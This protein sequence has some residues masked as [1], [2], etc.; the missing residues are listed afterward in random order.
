MP[1][2]HDMPGCLGMASMHTALIRHLTTRKRGRYAVFTGSPTRSGRGVPSA[3]T[4]WRNVPAEGIQPLCV[5]EHQRPRHH[6]TR[7]L[8]R[9]SERRKVK[10]LQK[11]VVPGPVTD[12]CLPQNLSTV[13]VDCRDLRVGRPEQVK[14]FDPHQV[15]EIDRV[16][17]SATL[18]TCSPECGSTC[19]A[20]WRRARPRLLDQRGP[21]R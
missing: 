17:P 6:H 8:D 12:R 21:P 3:A 10:A 19:S 1:S 14:P 16:P 18:C 11:G 20:G 9:V 2:L 7:S 13:H 5:D 15:V 4:R